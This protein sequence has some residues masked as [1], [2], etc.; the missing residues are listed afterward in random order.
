MHNFA[1]CQR[2]AQAALDASTA[3]Q[4]REAVIAIADPAVK[5]LL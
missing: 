1:S 3:V 5:D 4:A 2:M